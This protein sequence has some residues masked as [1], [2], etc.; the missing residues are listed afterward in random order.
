MYGSCQ[1][2]HHGG[3]LVANDI[4]AL[5]EGAGVHDAGGGD[6]QRHHV[7]TQQHTEIQQ[8]HHHLEHWEKTDHNTIV[9]D[10]YGVITN[11]EGAYLQTRKPPSCL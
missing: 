9:T 3:S 10:I 1:Q 7:E 5:F 6:V 8:H 2:T 11:V 4:R